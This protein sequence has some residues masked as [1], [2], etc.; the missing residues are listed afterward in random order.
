MDL[1]ESDREQRI[2]RKIS[3]EKV[4]RTVVKT[5][6]EAEKSKEESV[7]TEEITTLESEE[8]TDEGNEEAGNL[9]ERKR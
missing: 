4:E 5:E 7:N 9:K 1:E 8:I 6:S 3:S 2:P